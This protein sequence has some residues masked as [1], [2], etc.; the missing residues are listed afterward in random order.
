MHC[1]R[2]RVELG[3]AAEFDFCYGEAA[4]MLPAHYL[5]VFCAVVSMTVVNSCS[6]SQDRQHQHFKFAIVKVLMALT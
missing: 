6:T 5:F 2:N 3:V 1:R 4:Q